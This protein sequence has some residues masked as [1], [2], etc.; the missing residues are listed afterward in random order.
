MGVKLEVP[1][2]KLWKQSQD[3][4]FIHVRILKQAE[5]FRGMPDSTPMKL[6]PRPRA[7][8]MIDRG[9]QDPIKPMAGG[10][11]EVEP[12]GVERKTEAF[13][14]Q[15]FRI[16]H[17]N[18]EDRGMKVEMQVPVDVVKRKA[19]GAKPLELRVNLGAE[20]LAKCT[21]EKIPPPGAS[22]AVREFLG[23]VNQTWYF[24]LRKR[25]VAAQQR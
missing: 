5:H 7:E 12:E 2:W 4:A 14:P 19:G 20:L 18:R 10:Q 24:R 8:A 9:M 22:R 1:A 15:F 11:A 17:Q 21:P 6:R 25:R 13:D 3:I 16:L 23:G